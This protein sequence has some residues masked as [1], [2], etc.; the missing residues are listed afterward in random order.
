MRRAAANLELLRP[1]LMLAA[2]PGSSVLEGVSRHVER[3]LNVDNRIRSFRD[4]ATKTYVTSERLESV[5]ATL[6]AKKD[7]EREKSGLQGQMSGL[8]NRLTDAAES[9]RNLART[10][11]HLQQLF[12][13]SAKQ[14]EVS[15]VKDALVKYA[16]M[17]R[18]ARLENELLLYQPKQQFEIEMT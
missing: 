2:D 17:I 3:A 10:V 11:D 7:F 13:M 14:D 8:R 9:E 5:L 15:E 12:D 1:L 4:M 18:V 16:P 6:T